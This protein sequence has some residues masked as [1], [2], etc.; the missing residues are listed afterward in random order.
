MKVSVDE[1]KNAIYHHITHRHP[2][3]EVS[4]D[5]WAENAYRDEKN[6]TKAFG[7]SEKDFFRNPFVQFT[8][9]ILPCVF[10][11][12]LTERTWISTPLTGFY[13]KCDKPCRQVS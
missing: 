2:V 10:S 9:V 3:A 7:K 12:V 11:S 5:E 4:V 6:W 13:G 1:H 8:E